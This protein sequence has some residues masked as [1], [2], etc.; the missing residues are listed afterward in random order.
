MMNLLLIRHTRVDIKPGVCYGQTDVD[1]AETFSEEANQIKEQ[2]STIQFDNIYSSPLKRCKKLTE[3][4]FTKEI[5]FDNRLMEMNFGDWE[6]LNWDD[7]RNP[8]VDEW[9]ND[10]V[11]TSCPNGESF[12]ELHQRIRNFMDE[13]VNKDY[14]NVVIIS[15]GGPIR[16][17]L[18]FIN[19]N[20]LKDA[21]NIQVDYGEIIQ[22]SI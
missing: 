22:A 8:T 16:S 15:H 17:I 12:I 1:V 14:E 4:L 20:D 5:N 21:F 19:K 9:M 11:N 3:Y 13:L 6:L 7:L 2:L 10:F 18:T